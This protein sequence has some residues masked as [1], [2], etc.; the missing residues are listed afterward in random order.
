M[1]V[2]VVV[3]VAA[4]GVV[5]AAAWATYSTTCT[6]RIPINIIIYSHYYC[7]S[8][9]LPTPP[10]E[11]L[12]S[13]EHAHVVLHVCMYVDKSVCVDLCFSVGVLIDHPISVCVST[14]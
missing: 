2:V 4:V 1:V 11:G 6:I 8:Q 12:Y 7:Y 10:L 13:W 9:C 5:V 3:V 14:R